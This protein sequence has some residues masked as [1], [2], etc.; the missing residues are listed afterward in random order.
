MGK[1]TRALHNLSLRKSIVLYIIAFATLA[2]L[3]SAFTMNL[4][5][6]ATTAIDATAKTIGADQY[7]LTN[8]NGEQLG[9]GVIISG[10]DRILTP[11]Q[12]RQIMLLNIVQIAATPLYSA[13]CVFAA[14]MLFYKNKL[15]QPLA[16]LNEASDKIAENDLDFSLQYNSRDELGRLCLS[17]EKMRASLKQNYLQTWRQMEKQQHLNAAFA[18]D[19]RTPLTVLK[20]QS[21]MLAAYLPCGQM[22]PQKAADTAATMK[23]HIL[24]LEHYVAS[25]SQ[26]Q[27]LEDI[28][29]N[30]QPAAIAAL[31][32]QLSEAGALIC[33]QMHFVFHSQFSQ[34]VLQ[35][36]TAV[37]LQVYENLVANAAR[38]AKSVVTVAVTAEDDQLA[39][40]VADDGAGFSQQ[41][42]ENATQPFYQ[43][44]SSK[45]VD[46]SGL[47]LNICS[48]LCEKHGGQL[49]LAN[50]EI[51]AI[52]TARF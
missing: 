10:S 39:I 49:Q 45:S 41:D 29:I 30:P 42:L 14:A 12:N 37:V 28:A 19:L 48:L 3:L 6:R 5:S 9:T 35:L 18:H 7:Y 13:M 36:D 31:A 8:N 20:G 32:Q 24:R 52:V 4:C 47:G 21:D 16:L 46:H 50:G 25:M 43:S 33:G 1:I 40:K 27:Q 23:K 15:K 26:L 51:G 2:V 11:E 38:F 44:E 17:F 34:S 22:S